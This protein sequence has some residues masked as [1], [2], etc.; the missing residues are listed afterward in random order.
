MSTDQE[1]QP[2]FSSF[3]KSVEPLAHKTL[4]QCMEEMINKPLEIQ[5]QVITGNK[6]YIDKIKAAFDIAM[7]P[8]PPKPRRPRKP[9]PEFSSMEELYARSPRKRE[10]SHGGQATTGVTAE[11]PAKQAADM[12]KSLDE[13]FGGPLL[14]KQLYGK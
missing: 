11:S 13:L 4:K 9:L 10:T 8:Q 1:D 14:V 2:T 12:L 5:P 3:T 7:A 6:E